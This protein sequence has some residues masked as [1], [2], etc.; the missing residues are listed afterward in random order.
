MLLLHWCWVWLACQRFLFLLLLLWHSGSGIVRRTRFVGCTADFVALL[1]SGCEKGHA[2][3]WVVATVLVCPA[4]RWPVL[5]E[6]GMCEMVVFIVKL[7]ECFVEGVQFFGRDRELETFVSH[8]VLKG[9]EVGELRALFVCDE[10]IKEVAF[11]L[12]VVCTLKGR[13]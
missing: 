6:A 4:F 1:L 7:E 5:V 11:R 3:S 8:E 10:C 2:L 9:G 13:L 12:N